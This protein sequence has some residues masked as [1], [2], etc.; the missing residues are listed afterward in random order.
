MEVSKDRST[1]DLRFSGNGKTLKV[2]L[3]AVSR[4]DFKDIMIDLFFPN[5]KR[6]KER[7]IENHANYISRSKSK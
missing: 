4:N 2:E 5:K 6:K 7:M 3:K 1:C